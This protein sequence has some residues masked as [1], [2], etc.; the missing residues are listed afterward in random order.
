MRLDLGVRAAEAVVPALA[1]DLAVADE[2]GPDERVRA[3]LA[4]PSLGEL[5]GAREV[6]V[7]GVGALHAGSHPPGYA[8]AV[9]ARAGGPGPGGVLPA[10]AT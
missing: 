9:A 7:V 6:E 5:E 4:E 1:Q 3:D 2:H 8:R 10:V